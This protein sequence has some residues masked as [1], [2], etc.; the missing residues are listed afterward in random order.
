[1]GGVNPPE[2]LVIPFSQPRPSLELL[3]PSFSLVP[4]PALFTP[5]PSS[6]YTVELFLLTLKTTKPTRVRNRKVKS[7]IGVYRTSF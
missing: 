1:M 6:A 2:E 4:P 7:R 3:E 5:I